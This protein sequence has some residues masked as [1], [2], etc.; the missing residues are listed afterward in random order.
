MDI[1]SGAVITKIED[2]NT[3]QSAR[4][5]E[6]HMKDRKSYGLSFCRSGK[7]TYT[8]NGVKTVSD[9]NC[10]VLLP[11]NGC[12]TLRGDEA[13]T[14][15]LI[16]F[17]CEH[18][19]VDQILSFPLHNA[20]SFLKDYARLESLV[21]FPGNRLK[22][23]GLLYEILSRLSQDDPSRDRILLPAMQYLEANF[24]DP[25]LC[26]E[27]L[28]NCAGISEVYFR[29]IF[30]AHYGTTPKQYICD[31]RIQRAKQLLGEGQLSVSEISESCG[32]SGIHHFCRSFKQR[33]GMTPLEYANRSLQLGL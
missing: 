12:Y 26:N 8:M 27:T 1:F 5:R 17:Q 28:A 10:A 3:V 21:L 13:G 19:P 4:G 23:M 18:L 11:K 20:A 32:F 9:P 22:A 16:N 6:F 24:T 14:F 31:I 29:R 33:T 30:A 25:A 15:P 2:V 7:I